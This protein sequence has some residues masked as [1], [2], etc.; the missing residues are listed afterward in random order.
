MSETIPTPKDA[1]PLFKAF[2]AAR[3][4]RLESAV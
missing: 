4:L 1:L 3:G 2:L